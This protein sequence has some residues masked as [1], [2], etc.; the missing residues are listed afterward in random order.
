MN[1]FIEKNKVLLKVFRTTATIV[2][3][4]LIFGGG[5]WFVC[6]FS[7]NKIKL[8]KQDIILA[9]IILFA[10][11]S[12]I[13]GFALTG[14]VI[15]GIS[16]FIKYICESESKA[17]Y[18]VRNGDKV[19][20]IYAVFMVLKTI[21]SYVWHVDVKFAGAI[22]ESGF[23]RTLFLQAYILPTLAKVL[24]LIGIGIILRRIIPVI[25]ESRTLV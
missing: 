18:L 10:S 17:G 20:Y 5:F 24:I 16:Q 7:G 23:A 13:Y 21:C 11:S 19:L 6:L 1:E 2:G 3:F 14:L 25:E 12:L 8:E 4:V 15:L 22:G 9:D